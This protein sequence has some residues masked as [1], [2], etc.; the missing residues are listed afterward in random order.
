VF[1]TKK[2]TKRM[3]ELSRR[4]QLKRAKA[5]AEMSRRKHLQRVAEARANIENAQY[6]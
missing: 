4:R 3:Y 5:Q 6:K 1:Q 2:Q